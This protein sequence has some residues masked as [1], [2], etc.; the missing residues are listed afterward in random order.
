MVGARRLFTKN[1]QSS[2]RKLSRAQCSDEC[3]FVDQFSARHVNQE[4]SRFHQRKASRVDSVPRIGSQ[5]QVQRDKIAFRQQFVEMIRS[6]YPANPK[7]RLLGRRN[8]YPFGPSS[9]VCE[10]LNG[11]R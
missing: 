7:L 10:R 1:L 2:A 6:A 4:G 3:G 5:M 9:A 8:L 11:D